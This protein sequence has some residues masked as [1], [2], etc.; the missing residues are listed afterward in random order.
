MTHDYKR[1][2]TTDLFA[3]MN[4]ATGEVLYDT[5]KSHSSKDVLAFFKL[6]DLH[7]AMDLDIHVVLD[8]LSAT[9]LRRWPSGWP[10]PSE[11]LA[12]PLHAHQFELA[13]PGRRMVL[14]AHQEAT[15]ARHLQLHR[16]AHRGH[17]DVDRTLERR[18][19]PF[20]WTK[21][22]EA[23]LSKQRRPEQLYLL[24]LTPRRTTR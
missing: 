14:P 15:A 9:R 8:N 18:P 5:R 11:P 1:N 24:Q 23:I 17:R 6:I 7:V 12:P 13:E 19:H 16:R 10:I 20:I 4:V 21:T 22:A 3:A 2:G